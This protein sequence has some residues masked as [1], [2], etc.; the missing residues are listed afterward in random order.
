MEMTLNWLVSNW[1]R[2]SI[3]VTNQPLFVEVAFGVGLF[4]VVLNLV[5][6]L[7][8]LLAFLYAGLFARPGRVKKRIMKPVKARAT[9]PVTIDDDAPPFVFR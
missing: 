3:W 6:G 4:Y 5:K 2:F 8:K 1:D 9:K 7:Y